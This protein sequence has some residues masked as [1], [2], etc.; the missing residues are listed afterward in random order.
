[1]NLKYS[2]SSKKRWQRPVK[3]IRNDYQITWTGQT[4]YCSCPAYKFQR[5]AAKKRSCKHM[6]SLYPSYAAIPDL[7]P[8]VK[9]SSPN[10]PL[11]AMLHKDD[12]TRF[13]PARSEWMWS[14]KMDGIR[15]VWMNGKLITRN[16]NLI[17]AAKNITQRLPLGV[18]LD[19]ELWAGKNTFEKTL[20]AVQNGP[21]DPFWNKIKFWAFDI[22]DTASKDTFLERHKQLLGLEDKGVNVVTQLRVTN[23][24]SLK[25]MLSKLTY[26]GHEGI[27]VRN[28]V[29]LYRPGRNCKINLKWKIVSVGTGKIIR[30]ADKKGSW[31]VQVVSPAQSKGLMLQLAVSTHDQATCKVE[32]TVQFTYRGFTVSKKPKFAKFET[33]K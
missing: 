22:Y 14:V 13:K 16:G 24:L 8:F 5:K 9:T 18:N 28:A 3:G 27:V 7:Y 29:G 32:R 2:V 20:G 31:V 30:A 11:F 23:V 4:L 1:M 26:Q 15:A 10:V 21:E 25:R 6:E 12:I 17:Y 19:G 33:C